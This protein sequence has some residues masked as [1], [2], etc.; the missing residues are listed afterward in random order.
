MVTEANAT[1][2]EPKTRNQPPDRLLRQFAGY[3]MKRAYMHVQDDLAELMTPLGLRIGTMSALAVV[4]DNPG[5]SQTR[6]SEILDIKRSGV[7]VVVDE[8]E[9]A[10]VVERRPVEGDR[11]AYALRVTRAGRVLW[12]KA[13]A[14]MQ[15]YE[16]AIFAGL[17]DRDVA[18]FKKWLAM[19][20]QRAGKD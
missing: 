18:K 17:G 16:N 7:V 6:L 12:K 13:E 15:R 19:V 8:L 2:P 4:V 10:G 5:I 20:E 14:A 11:R 9:C 3:H 1:G